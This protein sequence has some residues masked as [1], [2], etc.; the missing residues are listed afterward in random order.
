MKL[1][2][3]NRLFTFEHKTSPHYWI[4]CL[5]P[6]NICSNVFVAYQFFNFIWNVFNTKT[7]K[8]GYITTIYIHSYP[9]SSYSICTPQD[10]LQIFYLLYQ[11]SC[12]LNKSHFISH[13][14]VWSKSF[15][16]DLRQICSLNLAARHSNDIFVF[17][18]ESKDEAALNILSRSNYFLNCWDNTFTC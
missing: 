3:S 8:I 1:V 12:L 17:Q 4:K 16:L 5:Y 11:V 15:A 18:N 6:I 13:F 7:I 14:W 2:K 10:L 9:V